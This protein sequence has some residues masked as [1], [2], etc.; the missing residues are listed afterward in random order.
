[1]AI[2]LIYK[3]HFIFADGL[4][5]RSRGHWVPIVDVSW[6]TRSGSTSHILNERSQSYK[7]KK[8]AEKSGAK[9]G[10]LWIDEGRQLSVL[11]LPASMTSADAERIA[12]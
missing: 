11:D 5:D 12:F 7:T 4:F 3:N 10:K 6:K 8:D 9:I 1:M 2:T